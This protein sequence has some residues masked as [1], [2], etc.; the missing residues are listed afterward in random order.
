MLV[1]LSMQ[2]MWLVVITVAIKKIK[3]LQFTISMS[4]WRCLLLLYAVY[5]LD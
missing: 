2:A 5:L 4:D 3:T 1:V